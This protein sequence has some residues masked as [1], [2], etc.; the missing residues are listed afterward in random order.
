MEALGAFL[1]AWDWS[2]SLDLDLTHH[3]Q[4]IRD[5]IYLGKYNHKQSMVLLFKNSAV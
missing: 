3:E 4:T 5:E 1:I 2:H